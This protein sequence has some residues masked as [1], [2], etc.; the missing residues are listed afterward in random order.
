MNS[1]VSKALFVAFSVWF[2]SFR[3][4]D[5]LVTAIFA[6][7]DSILD[8]G[9]NNN[10]PAVSR[11]NF[12]PYGINF[13]NGSPTGRYSNG[14]VPTDLIAEALGIK[15][16]VPAYRKPDLKPDDLLTGVCFAS[17]GSGL[18]K[19]T[20]K[21]QNVIW[22]RD[23]VNDFKDYIGKLNSV[24]GDPNKTQ[25]IISNAVFLISAGNNDIG[26]TYFSGAKAS[27]YS[28]SE[29]TDLLITWTRSILKD[30]YDVGVRKFGVMGTLPLGCL[31]FH[32]N[33][34][35]GLCF[36]TKNRVAKMFNHKLSAELS[37][38]NSKLPNARF[39]YI[40]MYNSFLDLVKNPQKSGFTTGTRPSCFR[41]TNPWWCVE[42]T[43]HVFFDYVHPTEQAFR[44][45]LSPAMDRL[46]NDLS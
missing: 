43:K 21:I 26:I 34:R 38:L 39:I 17:G 7:G 24:T 8:T 27:Q 13:P 31:P 42:P 12:F 14:K 44:V 30:L 37:D 9:N 16:T 20:A 32:T 2:S 4:T 46:R 23:Q 22:V 10:L 18:D 3:C 36:K 11:C 35:R 1:I 33:M 45:A 15:Q 29:Y 28:I 40:D 5:S 19:L 25:S 41:V 6:F